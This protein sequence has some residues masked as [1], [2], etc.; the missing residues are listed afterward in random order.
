MSK[1]T[2]AIAT[3]AIRSHTGRV[4][5]VIIAMLEVKSIDICRTLNIERMVIIRFET[6][7]HPSF[8]AHNF[9][10]RRIFLRA[11]PT[12]KFAKSHVVRRIP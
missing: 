6:I 3:T 5:V 9:P 4:K 12:A 8:C 10:V 1:P 11:Q 2:L 7:L